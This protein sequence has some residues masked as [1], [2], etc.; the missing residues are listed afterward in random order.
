[1]TTSFETEKKLY[2]SRHNSPQCLRKVGDTMPTAWDFIHWTTSTGRTGRHFTISSNQLEH[3]IGRARAAGNT[4]G[5]VWLDQSIS[6]TH[7]QSMQDVHP[8]RAESKLDC[9]K[10]KAEDGQKNAAEGILWERTN[11][12]ASGCAWCGKKQDL[13]PPLRQSR[14]KIDEST[15]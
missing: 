10:G 6:V 3:L 8:S 2:S 4:E 13:K 9:D 11:K 5:N 14:S 15:T 12:W 7:W 1:M